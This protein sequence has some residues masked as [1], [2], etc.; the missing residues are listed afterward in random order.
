GYI[1]RVSTS[2]K[3]YGKALYLKLRDG[4]IVVYGHLSKFEDEL[5]EEIR[6]LQMS[7]RR[8]NHN[9]FFTPDEYPVKRGQVIGYSGSSGARAPHLHFE[10]RS[11]G[12]NP[13]NPLKYGFPFADNRPPVFEKLAIRHYENGFAPGNPCDIEI[14]NVAEGIGAG[15]YVIGD[16]VIGTGYMAL[17]VSGG[18]RI[19]GKGFLYGFYSLRLRVD[20]SVIFS[21]NSDSIT[22]ETTG[23]LEYVRDME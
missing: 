4:R 16:T 13:L 5:G 22:Y 14:I 2:F 6:K 3:G 18:D 21:M 17:A 1:Y 20:D 19:D 15:E 7:V 12:N 23:Q 8:Y 11:A 10:I 9:L